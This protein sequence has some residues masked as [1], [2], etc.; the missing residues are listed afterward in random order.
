MRIASIVISCL[1][2][3]CLTACD[4][5]MVFEES[6]P[7]ANHTWKVNQPVKLEFEVKDT[8]AFHNFYITVRN[9]EDYEYSNLFVFVE[10]EFPNGKKSVDTVECTLAD[11]TGKWYG[12]GVG[13]IYSSR[14]FYK[15]DRRFPL[16]G[17]YK[18]NIHQGMREEDLKG[19]YD[20]G[21]RLALSR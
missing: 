15:G 3:L 8:T 12:D 17:R 6:R 16:S 1:V 20:V 18:V 7:I 4:S 9:G 10:M 13:S 11:P 21:F 14:I 2:V 5:K 19:V